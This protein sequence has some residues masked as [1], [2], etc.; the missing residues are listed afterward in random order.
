MASRRLVITCGLYSFILDWQKFAAIKPYHVPVNRITKLS[1]ALAEKGYNVTSLSSDVDAVST[2]NLHFLH[3]DKLYETIY[4]E[5]EEIVSNFFE[6][7]KQSAWSVI[8]LMTDSSEQMS[9]GMF[10]SSGWRQLL[11]YPDDFKVKVFF[12]FSVCYF[13]NVFSK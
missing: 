7:G 8:R 3:L 13:L 12:Y 4:A 10:L 2:P 5:D 6:F 11:V 9:K 1:I